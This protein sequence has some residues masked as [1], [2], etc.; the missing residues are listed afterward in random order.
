VDRI[1]YPRLVHQD[2]Y[3]VRYVDILS[4]AMVTS[5]FAGVRRV[6]KRPEVG[7]VLKL[8]KR[9]WSEVQSGGRLIKC[10]AFWNWPRYPRDRLLCGAFSLRAK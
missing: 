2:K 1:A 6:A 7:M 4:R 3:V 8:P 5:G 10:R 9:E